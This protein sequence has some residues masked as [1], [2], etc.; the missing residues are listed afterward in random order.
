MKNNK[1]FILV[2]LVLVCL[3]IYLFKTA[4]ETLDDGSNKQGVQLPVSV[5][6]EVI[7]AENNVVRTIYTKQI[8]GKSKISGLKYSED[9]LDKGVQAGPLPAL[10]LRAVAQELEK[11]PVPVSLFLGSDFP[12]SSAN[13]FDG[14]QNEVF[15]KLKSTQKPAYFYADGI[16]R[17]I[18]MFPD[19]AIAAACVDCHNKHPDT[20]K[21]DWKLGDMMGATTWLYPDETVT[22]DEITKTVAVLRASFKKVYAGYLL[23]TQGFEKPPEIG[24]KWPGEGYY[25]PSVDVF[26]AVYDAKASEQTMRLLLA[27]SVAL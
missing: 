12:I 13:A 7:A 2:S 26:F 25:L 3:S 19:Y 18:A 6:F 14:Q 20:P 15:Q 8:V 1:L 24:D 11:N 23:K 4:P 22:L 10:F 27:N 5:L 9:W 17:H 21:T 16:Q